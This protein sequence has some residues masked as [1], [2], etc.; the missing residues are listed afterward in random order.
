MNS[1]EHEEVCEYLSTRS[2]EDAVKD[3]RLDPWLLN[4]II[5]QKGF[6]LGNYIMAQG[7]TWTNFSNYMEDFY[8]R[9]PHEVSFEEFN[10]DLKSTLHADLSGYLEE[11][12]TSKQLPVFL[13]KDIKNKLIKIQGKPRIKSIQPVSLRRFHLSW[14]LLQPIHVLHSS[15]D[16]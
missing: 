14:R 2:L 6:E 5:K 7:I 9:F 12:Y 16:K 15:Q 10:Q 3:S 13:V 1:H 8:L 4:E 11:W